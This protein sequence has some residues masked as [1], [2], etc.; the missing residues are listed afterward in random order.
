MPGGI[1]LLGRASIALVGVAALVVPS[2]GGAT[3]VGAASSSS[4]NRTLNLSFLQDPGQ[5]PD[6]DVYY[7]GEGL[8]TVRNMYQGLVQYEP[9]TASRVIIPNLAT[10]WT[11]SPDG[12]TYTFQLRQGVQFHD[13]T[14]FT[15]AAIEPSFA[16][17]VR[18][19]TAVRPTW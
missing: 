15:S 1:S 10:S 4:A 2:L 19:S 3:V 13:G 8:L 16:L 14:P 7:A 5:P 18:R 11:I 6:P 9:G 12:L 17:V